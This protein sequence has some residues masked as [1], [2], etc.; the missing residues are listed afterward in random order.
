VGGQAAWSL[1]SIVL[2][3]PRRLSATKRRLRVSE[4]KHSTRAEVEAVRWREEAL[5]SRGA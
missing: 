3:A 4:G 2:Q 1:L 5:A